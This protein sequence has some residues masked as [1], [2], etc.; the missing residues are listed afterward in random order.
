MREQTAAPQTDHQHEELRDYET[1]EEGIGHLRIFG[2]QFRTGLQTL[3]NQTAHE[4]SGYRFTGYAQRQRGNQGS[5]GYGIIGRFR[6]RHAFNGAFAE[7]VFPFGKLLGGIVPQEAGDR[8]AST[9]QD[10]DDV[11]D[12]PG[13]DHMREYLGQFFGFQDYRIFKIN[14][15]APLLNG[16]FN[17][18]KHL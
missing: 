17:Q 3:D 11:P 7:L 14:N 6:S 1:C 10:T 8:C 18:H 15:V 12:D 4:H 5:A 2:E 9:G 13:T 16:F